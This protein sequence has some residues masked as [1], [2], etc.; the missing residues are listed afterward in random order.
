MEKTREYYMGLDLFMEVEDQ[1]LR[2]RNRGM[3][4]INLFEDNNKQGRLD[5]AGL[6]VILGY[7]AQLPPAERLGAL[8]Y[9]NA[10]AKSSGYLGKVTEH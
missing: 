3:V 6:S 8:E 9:F 10:I 1:E 7:F 2:D 4:M 5:P